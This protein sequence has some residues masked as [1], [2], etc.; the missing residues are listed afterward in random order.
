MPP[1]PCG[2]LGRVQVQVRRVY[3]YCLRHLAALFATAVPYAHLRP[4]DLLESQKRKMSNEPPTDSARVRDTSLLPCQPRGTPRAMSLTYLQVC[5]CCSQARSR[6]GRRECK[7]VYST[8]TLVSFR[9]DRQQTGHPQGPR[10]PPP[11]SFHASSPSRVSQRPRYRLVY[12]Q[13]NAVIN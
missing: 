12:S 13:G 10:P 2:I 1:A 11:E 5:K 8:K 7:Q 3:Y 9:S 6:E 4:V